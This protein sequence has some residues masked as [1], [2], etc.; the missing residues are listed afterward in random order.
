[1]NGHPGTE[2]VPIYS[3]KT[4]PH[5]TAGG[6]AGHGDFLYQCSST[7]VTQTQTHTEREALNAKCVEVTITTSQIS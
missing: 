3:T 2:S 5:Y 1:M 6:E 4:R 7:T